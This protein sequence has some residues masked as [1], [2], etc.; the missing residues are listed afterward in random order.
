MKM[1]LSTPLFP[2]PPH[3]HKM[4]KRSEQY[5]N[6]QENI[7]LDLLFALLL[8]ASAFLTS[9]RSKEPTSHFDVWPSE[10]PYRLPSLGMTF[11]TSVGSVILNVDY[12]KAVASSERIEINLY[13]EVDGN[14]F[15]LRTISDLFS[16]FDGRPWEANIEEFVIPKECFAQNKGELFVHSEITV[17]FNLQQNTQQVYTSSR[18]YLYEKVPGTISL[19]IPE[20]ESEE[21]KP[22]E[23][24]T[25]SS[26]GFGCAARPVS[27]ENSEQKKSNGGGGSSTGNGTQ[28]GM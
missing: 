12:R 5:E 4:K 15:P 19:T 25:P 28:S 2:A 21:E 1:P 18:H 22:V 14:V 3:N 27:F 23:E 13:A 24:Q 17:T 11:R 26:I 7:C 6:H 10:E 8:S 16:E 9:F 20:T